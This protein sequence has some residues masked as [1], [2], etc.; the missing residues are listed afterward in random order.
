MFQLFHI[1][2]RPTL[3]PTWPLHS[4]SPTDLAIHH[5]LHEYGHF[6]SYKALFQT[7][8]NKIFRVKRNKRTGK[9]TAISSVSDS[10]LFKSM[11]REN[12]ESLFQKFF[13]PVA[14]KENPTQD[15]NLLF[16]SCIPIVFSSC[17]KREWVLSGNFTGLPFYSN[18]TNC[19]LKIIR[20]ESRHAKG[21]V[22]SDI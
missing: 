18:N 2:N 3:Q 8:K 7:A 12:S 13:L 19:G 9:M 5:L 6:L 4:S 22:P 10:S 11:A 20:K 17:I 16:F 14:N 21:A 15:Y 1:F